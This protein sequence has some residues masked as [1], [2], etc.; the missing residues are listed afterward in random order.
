MPVIRSLLVALLVVSLPAGG[1]A[2]GRTDVVMLANGDR[3]TG[4]VLRLERGRLVFK[5]DDAGTL[6]LEWDKLTSVV[7]TRMVEVGTGDGAMYLGSLGKAPARAISVA[8]LIGEVPLGMSD[9]TSI[10][11]I[12][13]S[14]WRKL[15]GSVDAGFNY[16]QSSGIGQLTLNADTV[17]RR[18]ASQLRIVGSTIL[19]RTDDDDEEEGSDDRASVDLSYQRHPWQRWFVL[20]FGRFESNESLGLTLRSQLGGAVGPRLVNSNRAQ[21]SIGGGLGVND[22]RGVDVEPTRNVEAIFLLQTS[23]FT[24]DRPTTNLDL[25]LQYYPS[26]SDRGRHRA[27]FD[28]SIK[29]ELLK[30]LFAALT[31]YNSYDS[32][33]PNDAADRNDVGIVASVGWTY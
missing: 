18:P 31:L 20:G 6:Y 1:S 8:T 22:E 15:D 27:Q 32:R 21:M 24:Y 5:T 3:I 12:G 23:Y 28:A 14:F 2:Q 33:P 10:T 9:V 26:L 4:E 7:T 30:D 25:R 17:Y 16:T 13:R 19:T 11:P 29:Q